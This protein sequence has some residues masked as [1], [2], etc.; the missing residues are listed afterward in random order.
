MP[1]LDPEME[2]MPRAELRQ[3]QLERLQAT[4][5]R[6]VRNVAFYHRWFKEAQAL[7]SEIRTLEDT[8]RL[9]L[10]TRH[11]LVENQPYGMFAVPMRDVVRLH[12]SRSGEEEPI[13]I[14]H[15]KNDI[16]VWTHLKARGFAAAGVSETDFVQVYLDYSL[17]PGAVVAHY[18]AE[19]LGACVTPLYNLPI[20]DQ[21][22]I[23]RDYRTTVLI[24][25]PPRA[26][27]IVR[28]LRERDFDPK[29]LFL[30]TLILVGE[31]WS[32]SAVSPIEEA[33][34]VKVFGNYG[35]NE[36]CTPGIA[37]ECEEKNGLHINE[38]HFLPEIIDPQTGDPLPP[39]ARGELVLTTLTREAFPLVR[40]RTG[41]ITTLAEE[42]CPCGRTFARMEPVS[43]RT[44]DM[45]AV[46]GI[47][48]L[49]S[50][51]G[52]VLARLEHVT[53]R[54]CLRI[55]RQGLEDRLEVEVEVT[56]ALFQ[57]R[58]STMETLRLRIQDALYERLRIKPAV[59]LVEPRSL[60]GRPRVLDLR[61]TN[62]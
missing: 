60:E 41:D 47:E 34:F 27:H 31:S 38:D 26:V 11:T 35:V 8:A 50:E 6:I 23:M 40:F 51:V 10:I 24:C 13:V 19:R 4:L 20:A 44:D 39:G 46:E 58:I 62:A 18:G 25:T 52:A 36:I 16:L 32:P 1:I 2:T 28:Y 9:P 61:N 21:V 56:P 5:N 3:V 15:T 22:R 42:P 49:P 7:P 55:L 48:F 43:S 33:L 29:T 57:D 17:F 54:Y 59:K 45:L 37:F 14:G 30:R 12:P 53:S